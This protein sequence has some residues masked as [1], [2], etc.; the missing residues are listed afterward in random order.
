M[1]ILLTFIKL[2]NKRN[3]D[4]YFY[5]HA[6]SENKNLILSE[7]KK[8]NFQNGTKKIIDSIVESNASYKV[9]G[10]GSTVAAINFFSATEFFTHISTGG[11]AF[12]SLLEGKFLQGIEVL[13]E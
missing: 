7:I 6:T 10:G 8:S 11:G 5:F 3:N 4:F 12:L 13:K 1:P 2:M 9:A